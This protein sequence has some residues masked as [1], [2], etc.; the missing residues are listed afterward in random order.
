MGQFGNKENQAY[1]L[2]ACVWE[3]SLLFGQLAHPQ[4]KYRAKNAHPYVTTGSEEVQKASNPMALS[5]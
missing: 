2:C 3:E 1:C 5:L 4:E